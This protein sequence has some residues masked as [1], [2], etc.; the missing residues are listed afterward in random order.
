MPSVYTYILPKDGLQGEVQAIAAYGNNIYAGGTNGLYSV[1]LRQNH[2]QSLCRRMPEID[3]IC[4]A[5]CQSDDGLLAATSS[6]IYRIS[7]AGSVSRLTSKSTTALLVDGNRMYAAEPDGVYLYAM[8]GGQWQVA[9]GQKYND[10]PLVTEIR[11]DAHGGLWLASRL[12]RYVTL[13]NCQTIIS[14]RRTRYD[15]T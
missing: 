3:N 4:W 11:K 2:G 15:H 13:R 5:L 8:A 10:L 1:G 9:N 14:R 7:A 6:G 12:P